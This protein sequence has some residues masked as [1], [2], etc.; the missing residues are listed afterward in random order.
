MGCFDSKMDAKRKALADDWTGG[1]YAFA[2]GSVGTLDEFCPLDKIAVKFCGGEGKELKD[3]IGE[4]ADAKLAEDKAKE[5]GEK[6]FEALKK[7]HGEFKGG[8]DDGEKKVFGKYTAKEA[9]EHIDAAVKLWCDKGGLEHKMEEEA[10]ATAPEGMEMMEAAMEEMEGGEMMEGEM[11]AAAAPKR[12]TPAI[13]AFGEIAGPGE[14]PKLLLAMCVCYP[15][16][17][18]AVKAQ[19]LDYEL[20]GSGSEDLAA[21]A[22]IVGA[23]VDAGEKADSESWGCAWVTEDE[24]A[25]LKEVHAAKETSALVFPG[26]VVAWADKDTAVG[27]AGECPSGKK[28]VIFKFNGKVLKPCGDKAIVFHRQ[29]AKLTEL[30]EEDGAT[31]VELADFTEA[32][33][34]TVAEWSAKVK[35]LAEAA[36]AAAAAGADAVKDAMMDGEMMMEGEMMM[37]PPAE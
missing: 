30:K 26:T 20:G 21:V 1:E 29:F 24:L 34:A 31:V 36:A 5:L 9:F 27:C 33:F 12:D 28:K 2:V 11:A 16:F 7:L 13:D 18:D 19:V 35:E 22:T 37:D 23:F 25:E 17:G 32:A 14:I 15:A 3:G 4:L 6:I 8:K 10:A